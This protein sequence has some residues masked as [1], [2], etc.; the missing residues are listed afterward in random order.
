MLILVTYDVAVS[1]P[2]GQ[3]R[4]RRVAKV[5]EAYGMRVQNSVFECK[6]DAT[7]YKQL[8]LALLDIINE[9]E[10]SLRFYELGNNY[11][12]KVVHFGVKDTLN[13]EEPLIL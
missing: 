6:V 10:D 1:K 4:L 2:L 11:K 8:Q 7:Q 13:V 12:N 3:K 5:C 9:S